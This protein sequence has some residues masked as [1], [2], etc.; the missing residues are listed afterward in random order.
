MGLN[1]HGA[2]QHQAKHGV[3][4][5]FIDQHGV[6]LQKIDIFPTLGAT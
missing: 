5:R 6:L 4:Q 1:A 2:G 3:L